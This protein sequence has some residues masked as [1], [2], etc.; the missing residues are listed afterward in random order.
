M[1]GF[2]SFI[3]VLDPMLLALFGGGTHL[4]HIIWVVLW[5]EVIQN[6]GSWQTSTAELYMIFFPLRTHTVPFHSQ[7]APQVTIRIFM[8]SL[9]KM[10]AM[11]WQAEGKNPLKKKNSRFS[12]LIRLVGGFNPIEKHQSNWIIFPKGSGENK[13]TQTSN[14]L[15]FYHDLKHP[16]IIFR[17]S[18]F[19]LGCG[20]LVVDL[21]TLRPLS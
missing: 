10:A 9:A 19:L 16:Q 11:I 4:T 12:H 5:D 6:T 1:P 18:G 15:W 17:Y 13:K 20:N 2:S 3:F 21:S 14:F 8:F 7:V